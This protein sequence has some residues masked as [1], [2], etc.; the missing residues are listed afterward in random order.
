[1]E[2]LEDMVLTAVNNAL[3]A[4]SELASMMLESVTGGISIPGLKL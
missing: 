2:M 1:V 4:V 3:G